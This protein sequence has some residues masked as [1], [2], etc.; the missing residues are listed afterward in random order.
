MHRSFVPA[1]LR[2]GRGAFCPRAAQL[3]AAF[4]VA[5]RN[6][7]EPSFTGAAAAQKSPRGGASKRQMYC[8]GAR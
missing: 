5:L 3:L 7:K 4:P 6:P 2:G 8:W 1:V